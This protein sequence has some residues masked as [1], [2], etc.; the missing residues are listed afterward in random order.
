[1][2]K[3]PKSS[4]QRLRSAGL[5][6]SEPWPSSHVWPDNVLIGK[7]AAVPGNAIPAYADGFRSNDV[8]VQFDAPSV[9]LW[10]DRGKW[11]VLAE[12][13]VPGPGP[14]DF[15]DEWDT[16]DEAVDDILEFYFGDPGRMQAKAE[17]RKHPIRSSQSDA[18]ASKR[19]SA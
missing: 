5:F 14:G 7:P 15:L 2:A 10:F 16:I 4:I 1:M 8:H 3:I 6:V 17:T 9:R 19:A 18:D 12:E 13:Y 11:L